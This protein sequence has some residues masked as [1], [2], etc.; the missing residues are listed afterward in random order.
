MIVTHYK[1]GKD[2]V[3]HGT[4]VNPNTNEVIVIYRPIAP[5]PG[6]SQLYWRSKAEFDEKFKPKPPRKRPKRK[7]RRKDGKPRPGDDWI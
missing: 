5:V 3:V 1:N 4:A 6:D 2:Y 7:Y